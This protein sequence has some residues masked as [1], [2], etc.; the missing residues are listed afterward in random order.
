MEKLNL[1]LLAVD[2][3]Q[4]LYIN[5]KLFDQ[6]HSIEFERFLRSMIGRQIIVENFKDHYL[7]LDEDNE[8][9]ENYGHTFPIKLEDVVEYQ[10]L[11]K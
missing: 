7:E 9:L 1:V 6:G 8:Y 5:G 10:N 3:W 11:K 4:G 2:D